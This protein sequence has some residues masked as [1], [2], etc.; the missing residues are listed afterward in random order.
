MS[1]RHTRSQRGLHRKKGRQRRNLAIGSGGAAGAFLAFGLAPLAAAP[2]AHADVLDTILDPII[3]SLAGIDPTLGVD[4]TSWVDSFDPSFV[5]DS[6]AAAA[7]SLDAAGAA[8]TSTSTDYAQLFNEYIYTPINTDLQAWITSPFGE[9]VDNAIN[10]SSGEFLIGNGT[11]GTAADP[12]GGVGGLWFG[13]GGAGYEA[14]ADPGVDGGD[15]GNAIGWIGDGG[16]GG[17]GGAGAD[18][19]AGGAG[20][21]YMGNG[22][23]GGAGGDGIGYGASGGNGGAGGDASAWLFGNGGVGGAGGDRKSTRLNSSHR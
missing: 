21:I 6:A 2:P 7:S 23:A 14:S 13:D 17:A 9:Q 5:G 8:A 11:A 4:V 1:R 12:N 3:N 20:G 18:G 22:G 10:Q 15:G 19:G 16:D